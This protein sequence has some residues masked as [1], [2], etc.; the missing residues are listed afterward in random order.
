MR[1]YSKIES[2]YLSSSVPEQDREEKQYT[3]IT[4]SSMESFYFPETDFKHLLEFNIVL[5][6]WGVSSWKDNHLTETIQPVLL[7][8]PE[9]LIEADWNESADWWNLGAVVKE[10]FSIMIFF[11]GCPPPCQGYQLKDHLDEIV[12]FFGPFPKRLLERGNQDIVREIF[13]ENGYVK[14]S[15]SKDWPPLCSEML[16]P[17]DDLDDENREIFTSFLQTMMKIDPEDRVSV[18]DLLRHPWL[19]AE[20]E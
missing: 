18:G 17:G 6:D 20:Q 9:V 13:D 16:L 15:A 7:R 19:D 4:S 5:G 11:T 10:V 1:D 12:H 14:E 8:A 2:G 3:P